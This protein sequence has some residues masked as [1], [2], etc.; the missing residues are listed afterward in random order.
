M[1]AGGFEIWF[2]NEFDLP[3]AFVWIVGPL[4]WYGGFMVVCSVFI[5]TIFFGA[6][7][8]ESTQTKT[9]PTQVAGRA[10]KASAVAVILLLTAL[11]PSQAFAADAAVNYKAKCAMCH[12]PKGDGKTLMGTKLNIPAFQAKTI[13]NQSDKE[14]ATAISKGKGKMPAFSGKLTD[15]EA[16]AL[17]GFVRQMHGQ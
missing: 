13:Q 1:L 7:Q 16:T 3:L 5:R 12:G 9:A 15:V 8:S 14:L 10:A 4:L 11:V 6:S 2:R 17:A